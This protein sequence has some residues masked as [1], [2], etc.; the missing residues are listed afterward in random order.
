VLCSSSPCTADYRSP[1]AT[2]SSYVKDDPT[3]TPSTITSGDLTTGQSGVAYAGHP[4]NGVVI[5]QTTT[6]TSTAPTTSTTS[7]TGHS[8]QHHHGHQHP[9]DTKGAAAHPT[10]TG[11]S[12]SGTAG[13]NAKNTAV[14][15]SGANETVHNDGVVKTGDYV[16]GLEPGLA[17]S[18]L[19]PTPIPVVGNSHQ[20]RIA[21]APMTMGPAPAGNAGP[22]HTA[23]GASG[24][25]A[26]VGVSG[27]LGGG[28]VLGGQCECLRNGGTCAHPAGQCLCRG[29]STASTVVNPGMNIGVSNT[30]DHTANQAPRV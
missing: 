13:T 12:T 22:L 26:P 14:G 16:T 17:N 1:A 21:G 20:N 30:V 8:Q 27:P 3:A 7:T 11:Q 6:T 18:N 19:G 25:T 10:T 23:P 4:S 2:H 28:V 24:F 15:V 9:H 29:C 5:N